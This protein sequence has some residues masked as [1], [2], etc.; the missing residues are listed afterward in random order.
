MYSITDATKKLCWC[1]MVSSSPDI[2]PRQ[3]VDAGSQSVPAEL[4]I[5]AFVLECPLLMALDDTIE[6]RRGAMIAARGIYRDPVHS[7]HGHFVKTSGLRWQCL[8]LVAPVPWPSAAR[9]C[10]SVQCWRRQSAITS[11]VGDVPTSSPI[12]P[13]KCC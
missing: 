5:D 9:H 13:D 7:S 1:L 4:I 12:A 10:R 11:N 6:R 2:E 8:M 3:M